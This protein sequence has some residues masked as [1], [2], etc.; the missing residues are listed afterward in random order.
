MKGWKKEEK[1]VKIR[2]DEGRKSK[3][4]GRETKKAHRK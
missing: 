1:N 3:W 4:D 2:K